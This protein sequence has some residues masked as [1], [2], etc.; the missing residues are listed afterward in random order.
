MIEDMMKLTKTNYCTFY[1]EIEKKKNIEILH[2]AESLGMF[3]DE[4]A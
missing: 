3:V 2:L 1:D 4:D